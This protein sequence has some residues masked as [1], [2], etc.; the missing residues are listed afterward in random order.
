MGLSNCV[1]D[2]LQAADLIAKQRGVRVS[3]ETINQDPPATCSDQVL[4]LHMML[5]AWILDPRKRTPF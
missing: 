5:A 3:I 4:S 2:V 1:H